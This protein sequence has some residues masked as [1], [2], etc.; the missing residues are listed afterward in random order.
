MLLKDCHELLKEPGRGEARACCRRDAQH[1]VVFPSLL[2]DCEFASDVDVR[3]VKRGLHV[4]RRDAAR[5]AHDCPLHDVVGR[6]LPRGGAGRRRLAQRRRRVLALQPRLL[7]RAAAV[8]GLHRAVFV[9]GP[10]RAAAVGCLDATFGCLDAAAALMLQWP[11]SVNGL[12]GQKLLVDVQELLV[13]PVPGNGR[14]RKRLQS[15]VEAVGLLLEDQGAVR[16]LGEAR[17][18]YDFLQVRQVRT[19]FSTAVDD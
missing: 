6:H 10:D 13:D 9:G 4:P 18:V 19:F 12:D 2:D 16:G 14:L 7:H 3:G 11:V 15:D 1:E 8:D 17:R 5:R